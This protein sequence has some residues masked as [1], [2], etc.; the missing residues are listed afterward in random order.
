MRFPSGL[1]IA[2]S[3]A[4][5]VVAAPLAVHIQR[6]YESTPPAQVAAP[7]IVTPQVAAPEVSAPPPAA[8]AAAA[9]V[10]SVTPAA[11]APQVTPPAAE[12]AKQP[13]AASIVTAL[14]P[15]TSVTRQL[16]LAAAGVHDRLAGT[17]HL[18]RRAER[19]A[20]LVAPD[21]RHRP[22]PPLPPRAE[23]GRDRFP[24][25]ATNPVR[26]TAAEPVSTFSIDVD[27]SSYGFVRKALNAGRL[28]PREAVRIEEMVNYFPYGYPLPENR[29]APFKPTVTVLPAPWNPAN[30]LVHIAIKGYDVARS[31]RPRANLVLLIDTSGSMAPEDRL[32]LLKNAFRMLVDTLQPDD[33][34][35]IVTYA[36]A[37][38]VALEPTKVAEK[39]K[40]VDAIERLHAGGATAGAAGIQQAY[41]MAEAA[42]DKAAVNRVILATDGDFNVGIASVAELKGLVERKRASGVYLSILG[43]G[44]GNYNDA[45]MQ[46]LAQNGNGVAA[47]IDTLNEARKVLVEE[48]SST[49]FPIARDVK[50]QVE[51]NPAR[52]AEY[53]LIGYDTRLL[54]REDFAND[55]V[56][57]GDIGSGH[58]VTALYEITPVGA[59]K[60]VEDLRYGGTSAAQPVAPRGAKAGEYAFLK[61]RYKL[62]Q[63][64][65]SRLIELPVTAAMEASAVEQ[66]LADVRFS[67]AVAAFGQLLRGEPYLRSYGFDEV[68][69]LAGS[70]RGDDPFGYRAEFLSL[71]RLA[72]SARP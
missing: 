20:G 65:T 31:E 10:P 30:K 42:F 40:I 58:A 34:V 53:R 61:I 45:L 33:S 28:P 3:L 6:T 49:L 9:P 50:I 62:P 57:A 55:K 12:A 72:K 27:T 29:S 11:P 63:E 36:G 15:R 37:T 70:A 43:V 69:A 59:P 1:A 66:A 21:A 38:H 32:P 54:R 13:D 8:P 5:L 60:L 7:P 68:I 41:R 71:V 51:F 18:A 24:A 67:T 47:Y 17:Q 22:L 52:V 23:E 19:S 26:S 44:R 48:A 2:A 25:S 35:G 14:Q 39:H 64:D 16:P 4:V 56:D 46:A